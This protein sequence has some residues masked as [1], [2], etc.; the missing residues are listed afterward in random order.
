M[1]ASLGCAAVAGLA[2]AA[3]NNRTTPVHTDPG[4]ALLVARFML[5]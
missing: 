1:M 3:N 5:R 4:R 2:A